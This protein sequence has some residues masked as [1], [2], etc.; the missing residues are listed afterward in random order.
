MLSKLSVKR[1]MAKVSR[2][3]KLAYYKHLLSKIL[4]V[5]NSIHS[6]SPTVS[7]KEVVRCLYD[8]LLELRNLPIAQEIDVLKTQY[9]RFHYKSSMETLTLIYRLEDSRLTN[10]QDYLNSHYEE[11][12]LLDWFSNSESVKELIEFTS[13]YV[14]AW[15][16]LKS[17]EDVSI[18]EVPDLWINDSVRDFLLSTEFKKLLMD[19]ITML[20]LNLEILI[21]SL[22]EETTRIKGKSSQ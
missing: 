15:L 1:V 13:V 7:F 5:E 21:G 16:S 9:G 20:I 18:S 12:Q 22:N 2:K 17:N 3:G 8:Y 6:N 19:V 4:E 14:L 10:P 11:V